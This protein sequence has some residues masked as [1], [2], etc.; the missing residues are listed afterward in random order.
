MKTEERLGLLLWF[1]LSRFYNKSIRETNQHLKEWSLSAAQFDVL[2]QIGGHDRLTQQELGR[3]LFVTKGNITQ[4]LNKMEQLDWIKREQEG[5]TKYL[6]LTEKGRVLYEDV[7]PSQE[8]FQAERFDKL[9]RNEQKQ[10]LE[11]LRK[12]Q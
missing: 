6:S 5:T 3:K 10:L 2:A 8:T 9:N 12:L 4:L 11:L 1:R 7:V